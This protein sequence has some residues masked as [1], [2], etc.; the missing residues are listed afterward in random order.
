[1]REVIFLDETPDTGDKPQVVEHVIKNPLCQKDWGTLLLENEVMLR[2]EIHEWCDAWFKRLLP[3][4]VYA[5][6]H[7][8]ND[9]QFRKGMQYMAENGIRFDNPNGR[10]LE[11]HVYNKGRI[12][13]IFR[14]VLQE[15]I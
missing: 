10:S 12:V 5:Q 2:K 14:I 4:E 13:G 1:M 6:I 8:A 9:V 3:G 7:S 11:R 15:G